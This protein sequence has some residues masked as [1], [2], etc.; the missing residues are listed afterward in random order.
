MRPQIISRTTFWLFFLMTATSLTAYAQ[1]EPKLD[2]YARQIK[3]CSN[4][5]DSPGPGQTLGVKLVLPPGQCD[6]CRR[7]F[8]TRF[9]R[10]A[11]VLGGGTVRN[12]TRIGNV[13][14]LGTLNALPAGTDVVCELLPGG[15]PAPID[16]GGGA[17]L[18]IKS[19]NVRWAVHKTV[20]GR[21]GDALTENTDFRAPTKDLDGT[22]I[23]APLHFAELSKEAPPAKLFFIV[24]TI[25]VTA[26]KSL[27]GVIT[28]V[29]SSEI[30]IEI[31]VP[32][33]A[34]QV[35]KVFVLFID[36][37]F[38]RAAAIY[39]P[40]NASLNRTTLPQQVARVSSTYESVRDSLSFVGWFGD[41]LTGLNTLKGVFDSTRWS[42]KEL[43][44][45][46]SNLNDDDFI[47][48]G[49]LSFNDQEVED[50]SSS[51]LLLGIQ[52][53]RV[54]FFQHRSFQGKRFTVRTG[55]AMTVLIR[56]FK[57]MTPI[58]PGAIVANSF[59]GT[60]ANDSLSSFKWLP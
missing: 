14:R 40:A 12:R 60:Q 59:T 47:D 30:P 11:R 33:S 16:T 25:T 4:V 26:D 38:K 27:A 21:R 37:D 24:A 53:T 36:A 31:P 57:N 56:D 13:R 54:Q 32:L 3:A 18:T 29:T 48:N 5:P 45:Q 19:I 41:Y 46:E 2:D 34:L 50:E 42:L 8:L 58:P 6:P 22:F 17:I 55:P 44:D 23:L 20:N 9:V 43:K 7:A 49:T 51:L 39:L 1:V 52:G 28:P 35:P 15:C 10:P